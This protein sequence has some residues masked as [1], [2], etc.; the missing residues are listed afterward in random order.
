MF[1]V[2]GARPAGV[3]GLSRMPGPA[4]RDALSID[5]DRAANSMYNHGFPRVVRRKNE[6]RNKE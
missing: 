1:G 5:F 6:S 3:R 4:A 2:Q